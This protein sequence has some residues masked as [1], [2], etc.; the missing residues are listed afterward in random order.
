MKVKVKSAEGKKKS[1]RLVK[2]W[3]YQDQI[4][5]RNAN[6]IVLGV[7]VTYSIQHIFTLCGVGTIWRW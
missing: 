1:R 3:E 2:E 6:I 5:H 7:G 4:V